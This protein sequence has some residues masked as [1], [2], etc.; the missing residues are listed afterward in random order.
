MQN[1]RWIINKAGLVNFWYY[2]EEEFIF[3][4]GKLLLRGS[5]GSGKSVTMQSF[6]PLLLD[7]NKSPE[8]LDPFGSKSR[9]IE[10]YLLGDEGS[11]K[12]ES[13][14]YL[15]MEFKKRET[16]NYLTIGMGFKAVRGKSIKSWGFSI[17]DGRR[18][19]KDIFLYKNVGEKLPLTMKELENRIGAGG[20]VNDTQG[21][22]VKMVNELLFGFNDIEEYEE[23]VKLMVQLRTPK[24]SKDFKPTVIYEIMEN[25]LQPLSED[26]LRP[27]SEAIENMDNIKSR[28][29]ELKEGKKAADRIKGV[30]DKY[31]RVI[32]T[33]KAKDYVESKSQVDK[34][35]SD[36][37]SFIKEIERA[38]E[39]YKDAEEELKNLDIQLK[40]NEQ[41]KKELSEHDSVRIREKMLSL[42][43]EIKVVIK[44]KTDKETQIEKKKQAENEM[45]TRIKE[46]ENEKDKSILKLEDKLKIMDD[47]A[48]EFCFDEQQFL[49]DELKAS[50]EKEYSFTYIKS[51][52]KKYTESI[53]NA[54][55][56][57]EEEERKNKE[58]DKSLQELEQS[59]LDREDKSRI[60]S[61]TTR[62]LDEIKQEY[63]E[64]IYGWRKENKELKISDESIVKL[65]Q[66]INKFDGT[67][68]FDVVLDPVRRDYS[69]FQERLNG[70]LYEM[71]NE[72]D[73]WSKSAKEKK[74]EIEAWK[75]KKDPEP[76]REH[77]ILKSR[78][79]LVKKGIPF[80]P[81][82]K[83][84]D[85][86]DDI[87]DTLKGRVEEALLDMG[88]LDALII[89]EKFKDKVN[90]INEEG[91]DKYLFASANFLTYDLSQFLKIEH[92]EVEGITCQDVENVLKSILIDEN[93][94]STYIDEKGNYG[95]G[96]LRGN[97]SGNYSPKFIG[98]AA[99]K[100]YRE[101]QIEK[102]LTELKEMETQIDYYDNIINEVNLKLE[103]L[104]NEYNSLPSNKDILVALSELKTAQFN[105]DRSSDDVLKKTEIE[106]A[107]YEELKKVKEKVHELTYKL[108]INRSVDA[109]REA[110]EAA[111]DYKDELYE[112]EKI[113]V[114][115]L[116]AEEKLNMLKNQQESILEDMDNLLY[117]INMADRKLKE[118]QINQSN[119]KQQLSI[120]DY[121]AIKIELEECIRALD[122]IP[123]KQIS[124]ARKS[125]SEMSKFN[126]NKNELLRA[127]EELKFNE[128]LN[129]VYENSFVEEYELGYVLFENDDKD[130]YKIAKKIVKEDTAEVKLSKGSEDY[131]STLFQRFQENNQYLREYNIKTEYIFDSI[132]EEE[133]RELAKSLAKRK[134]INIVATVRGKDVNFY[135]L[136]DFIIEGIEENENLLRESD[137]E[138]FED[139]LVKNISKKIRAKIFHSE[140]WVNKMNELM[141]SMNTSSGLSFSLKWSN[142][143]A[144][145][146]EQ[147]D[148]KDLVNLLKQDG[149]LM[150]VED[151]NKLSEH[152]RSKITEA[153]RNFEDKGQNQTFHSIMREI[154]DYRK[155][156]EFKLS[157]VKTG[158]GKKE[159]TNNAFFQFSGGEK[160]MA[161]YVPLFSAVY[162][163]YEG[164]RK[165][166]PRIISLDEAFAGVDER[167]IRDMFRL[168]GELGLDYIINSQILWG[169]Y[170]TV[171][172]LAICELIRPD[173]A[174]FV[175]VIRYS[176]NGKVK[177]LVV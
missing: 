66:E 21:D 112:L 11:G 114:I 8:R 169:D 35:I 86:N 159:L 145:T 117:D 129:A 125:E 89:P 124:V 104:K 28:L 164:G 77:K 115:L 138:L 7:G 52:L 44:E 156:F 62:L 14:G 22:Y 16:E 170:D 5:N 42:E 157:F 4:D 101:E 120:S 132:L 40:T 108:T 137:R 31:N 81:L 84:V 1:N 34:C 172:S 116:K 88:L 20:Q 127:E 23:L 70:K 60:L 118:A 18:I 151:L 105:Y 161:M 91:A 78:E 121:E 53:D 123:Q 177:E 2:D 175:T 119:L 79:N 12:D 47:Y 85:F 113:H 102:L 153:R 142:K 87:Q 106:K 148:T 154:L 128:K 109:F 57:L 149:N 110:S 71:R 126:Q 152:F 45:S 43:N 167:N 140:Q 146:E 103:Q 56:A 65:S 39:A 174:D 72:K 33:N 143:K 144:E 75:A 136:I 96:I 90:S 24:L 13:V 83:A 133:N 73:K 150:R 19:G 98:S 163:R 92:I 41:K 122:E 76:L 139:I 54:T 107:L 80:I 59:K 9:K 46:T 17:T 26:D 29:E 38:E 131:A 25:S 15:Y 147:L 99:R 176:W 141:E 48:E 49:K 100:K 61:Q 67:E 94:S 165:D 50:F 68:S 155:W 130:Y 27:M 69:D 97:V 134:R 135:K 6:I 55:K 51:S 58:Y 111:G 93:S 3:S 158:Q 82:Y 173:N 160:A 64:N 32:I 36:K 74:S 10:N 30:F 166:S 63:I 162:A 37:N 168:V 95:I 171:P